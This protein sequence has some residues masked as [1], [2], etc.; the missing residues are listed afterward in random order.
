M[1]F[2]DGSHRADV[3]YPS[4]LKRGDVLS[5]NVYPIEL[6]CN[7]EPWVTLERR[8]TSSSSSPRWASREV[9]GSR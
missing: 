5:T 3:D 2:W 1:D 6:N 9:N 7:R 4:L 8:T